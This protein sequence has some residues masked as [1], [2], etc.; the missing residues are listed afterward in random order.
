MIETVQFVV[1]IAAGLLALDRFL[2]VWTSKQQTQ[3]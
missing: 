3:S 2:D 1:G